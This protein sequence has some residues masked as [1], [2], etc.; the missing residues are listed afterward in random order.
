MGEML[1]ILM[2][3][4]DYIQKMDSLIAALATGL[5]TFFITKYKY[6]R[7]IPL[8][9][10]EI[11]YNRIYYP[12]YYIT[13]SN[14]DIQQSMDKCKKYLTKYRKYADKTTL[15][16]FE[17]FEGAKFDNIAYKQFEKN[18]DKMN[19]KLRRRLGYLDSN[20]ITTYNYLGVFEKS[21]L[22]IVLE[23][24]VIYIL[25]FIVGYAKGKCALILAYVELSLVLVLAIEGICMIGIGIAIGLKESFLSKIRKKDIFKE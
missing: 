3:M 23:V 22:R 13:K 12:I 18:I 5:I 21:M 17:N 25:T 19:T 16:A 8:D 14:A 2:P 6:H 11:A 4:I 9:K 1:N 10:L 24:I 15:R 20:I 7:N